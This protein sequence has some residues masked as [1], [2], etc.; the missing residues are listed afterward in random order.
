MTMMARRARCDAWGHSWRLGAR[1]SQLYCP[2][3][4][5]AAHP[6]NPT[7]TPLPQGEE[8]GEGQAPGG[9]GG[10]AGDDGDVSCRHWLGC[11]G[12]G[13]KALVRAA[14]LRACTTS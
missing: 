11:N 13:L 12:S 3:A 7:S 6:P 2:G 10:A 4:P 1:R 5:Q 8:G 14:V 9:G